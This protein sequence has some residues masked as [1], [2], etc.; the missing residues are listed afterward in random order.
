[1]F[2]LSSFLWYFNYFCNFFAFLSPH[3][4]QFLYGICCRTTFERCSVT[5]CCEKESSCCLWQK[6]SDVEG[7]CSFFFCFFCGC[8]Q[9]SMK[10]PHS[11][12]ITDFKIL[13]NHEKSNC[14]TFR[15][16]LTLPT[17]SYHLYC[18]AYYLGWE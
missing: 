4:W 9:V 7:N 15:L 2:T 18:H 13:S 17:S 1:M 3:T 14:W 8:A 10:K 6:W 16:L 11:S 12:S 5:K